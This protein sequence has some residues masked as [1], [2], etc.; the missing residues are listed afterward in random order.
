[1]KFVRFLK[2]GSEM[3]YQ[4]SMMPGQSSCPKDEAFKMAH[5]RKNG[6]EHLQKITKGQ[7]LSN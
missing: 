4:H 6:E 3:N 2:S 5:V 7:S 1:M